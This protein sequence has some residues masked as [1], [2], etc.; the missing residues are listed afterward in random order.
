L[1][2]HHAAAF[3]DV[4]YSHLAITPNS[5]YLKMSRTVSIAMPEN[6]RGELPWIVRSML[7]G[8]THRCDPA[9]WAEAHGAPAAVVRVLKADVPSAVT[10]EPGWA[11]NIS[12]DYSH[13]VVAFLESLTN[14]SA[15]FAILNAGGFLRIPINLRVGIVAAG[16]TGYLVGE[17]AARPL[18]KL[19]LA[20]RKLLGH[21]AAALLVASQEVLND[22]S[23][24]GQNLF[25]A[26]LRAAMGV[27]VDKIFFDCLTSTGLEQIPAAGVTAETLRA[28]F[29]NALASVNP[30]Q[31]SRLYWLA[32][33]NTTF[34]LATMATE[35]GVAAFPEVG[36]D[37]GTLLGRPLIV[38]DG[39]DASTLLLLD[40]SRVA[41]NADQVAL[42]ASNQASI[43]MSDSASNNSGAPTATNL[44]SMFETN[45]VAML[46]QVRV[47]CELLDHTAVAQ[48]TGTAFEASL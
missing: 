4:L 38:S 36:I 29:F 11:G 6:G 28:A 8:Q 9:V 46:A 24:A 37:G 25:N 41:A 18:S 22:V 35:T 7:A 12:G 31:R 40:A 1:V 39:V 42:R 13:Q 33:R 27:E 15:F 20:N 3:L 45:S 32:P 5:D 17:S 44:V 48:I 26:E 21:T 14:A 47:A 10:S 2:I 19:Q 43:E 16:A 30:A 23:A 34:T